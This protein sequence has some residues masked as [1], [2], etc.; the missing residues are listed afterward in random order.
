M[1]LKFA[2]MWWCEDEVCDCYQPRI[3]ERSN[4]PAYCGPYWSPPTRLAE[5]PF[6]SQPD[7]AERIEQ[8]EWLLKHARQFSVTNLFEIERQAATILAPSSP[9]P[10]ATKGK[11]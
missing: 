11:L 6:Y 1:R 4:V 2:E 9:Q 10:T 8:W 7:T 5:G 3:M